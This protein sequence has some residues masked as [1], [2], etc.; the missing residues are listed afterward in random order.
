MQKGESSYDSGEEE[1]NIELLGNVHD[2][3]LTP[4]KSGVRNNGLPLVSSE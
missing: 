4:P 3:F 2:R 1:I